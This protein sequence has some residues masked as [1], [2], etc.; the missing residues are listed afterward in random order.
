MVRAIT[1]PMKDEHELLV[2]AGNKKVGRSV[3]QSVSQSQSLSQSISK[4]DF[5]CEPSSCQR[6]K[7]HIN[8]VLHGISSRLVLLCRQLRLDDLA[9]AD[10]YHS[11]ASDK[12]IT[13]QT[14]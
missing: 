4:M 11:V 5:P 1:V 14:I 7:Q 8:V 2:R 10:I 3:S 13:C 12:I 6:G 9:G